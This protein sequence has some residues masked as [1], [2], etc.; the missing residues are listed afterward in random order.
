MT[1]AERAAAAVER[2][3][4]YV[5]GLPMIVL[6]VLIGVLFTIRLRGIQVRE[7]KNALRYTFHSEEDAEG[8]VTSFGALCTALAATIGTGNIV[9]VATA[10]C[11]GGPGALFWMVVTAVFG[12]ATQFAEG[13]LAVKFRTVDS[14]GH[15]L[16][17]PFTYIERGMGSRWKWLARLFAVFAVIAGLFGIGTFTQVNGIT[18]AVQ[19][20]FSPH[21]DPNASSVLHL[22]GTAFAWPAVIAGLLVTAATA[23]VLLG[24]MQR[25][26]RVAEFVVPFMAVGYTLINLLLLVCNFSK[27]PEAVA[28]VV[29]GAFNPR[30]VTGGAIGSVLTVMQKGVSR[31]VFTNEAGMGTAAIAAASAKTSSPVR[32]GLVAMT[33]TFIDTVVLCTMTG[34]SIVLTGAWNTGLEGAAVTSCAF[35]RG[36]PFSDDLSAFLL[37]VSLVF[38]AFATIIG[39]H[40]YAERCLAYLSGGSERATRIYRWLYILAVLIG[41][42]LSVEAVWNLADI[43]NGLMAFPNLIAL[44]ALSGVVIA[45]VKTQE[46]QRKYTPRP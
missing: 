25:I 36:L 8:E 9:G 45:E 15:M 33:G 1:G 32:Q 27:I 37:M 12:M 3:N 40:F 24:G 18:T 28:M 6:I 34:L 5:W 16:G 7:L 43:T 30:A 38:F 41:P 11:A 19:N 39:W 35:A 31:G 17:G 29:Q 20:F 2:V 10:I 14:S 44:Y 13:V 4:S 26:T 21:F 23:L 42:Y 46:R 22:F